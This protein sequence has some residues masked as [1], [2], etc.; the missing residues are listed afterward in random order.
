MAEQNLFGSLLRALP[1]SFLTIGAGVILLVLG[2]FGFLGE[3]WSKEH[4]DIVVLSFVCLGLMAVGLGYFEERAERNG[5]ENARKHFKV[6]RIPTSIV[7]AAMLVGFSAFASYAFVTV[8]ALFVKAWLRPDAH[9]DSLLRQLETEPASVMMVE[10]VGT[11][12][13]FF[14]IAALAELL[15]RLYFSSDDQARDSDPFYLLELLL[16]GGTVSC[17][18]GLFIFAAAA[19]LLV[20]G[21]ALMSSAVGMIADRVPERLGQMLLWLEKNRSIRWAL[22]LSGGLLLGTLWL[23]AYRRARRIGIKP[24]PPL[25]QTV[26]VIFMACIALNGLGL[27]A[28]LIA[29][30]LTRHGLHLSQ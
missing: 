6:A 2:Y 19:I 9:L 14:I 7:V 18:F 26:L 12:F 24:L 27:A 29:F 20:L 16:A 1:V 28:W 11:V 4:Q 17:I 3:N 5:T 10:I 13:G 23:H 25:W 30:Q 21:L 15:Y 8:V 22:P